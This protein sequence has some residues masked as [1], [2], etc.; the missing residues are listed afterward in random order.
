[1]AINNWNRGRTVEREFPATMSIESKT[2]ARPPITAQVAVALPVEGAFDYLIPEELRDGLPVGM[3]VLVPFGPR[4]VTGYVVGLGPHPERSATTPRLK[5]ILRPLDDEPLF[6]PEMLPFFRF[7]AE[8]YHYP[9]GL[10]IAEALPSGLKVMSRRTIRLT[11][12]GR[13]ALEL[14]E[15][16]SSEATLMTRLDRSGGLSLAGLTREKKESIKLVRTLEARSWI[17]S[18][19]GFQKDRVRPKIQKWLKPL[20]ADRAGPER[21]GPKEKAL[22]ESLN[23]NGPTPVEELRDRFPGLS[24]MIG[25][26]ERKGRL[27]VEER[28]VYRDALG[29]ALYFENKTPTLTA[30]QNL[31]VAEIGQALAGGEFCP[32]LLHGI[33][34][35]GKT[36][37][38][39]QAMTRTLAQGRTALVLVP[40]ISLTPVM[41]GLCRA[42]FQ[43]EVG[44][45][46][47][48][49][50]DGERYDQWLKI[51]RGR[52]RVVLGARSAV[53]A[54]LDRIGLI[55]VDEEHDGAYKQD[56]KLR[57]NGRDLAL[58]RGQQA[59]AVVILGSATPSVETY[60]AARSGR[61]RLLTLTRRIGQVQL[62]KVDI[63]DLRYDSGRRRGALTPVLKSA[64][65]ETLDRGEQALLFINRRGLAGTPLCLACG[66]AI[67]CL[68]CSVTMTLH[69]APNP[70]QGQNRLVCH[71]CGLETPPPTRCPNCDSKL[72][73][74]VGI[75]TERLQQEVEKAFPEAR[76]GRLDADTARPKGQMTRILEALRDRNL[77]VL[78]GTQM[79]TKGHDFPNITLVGVI[80]ADLGLH[81]PDFRA[82]ERVF[83]LLA[84]VAG[85][86]G[87]GQTPGRVIIQT[88]SPD[89][90][91]LN[92]AQKHDYPGFFKIEF[93]QR[94]ESGYP[95]FSRLVL[96]RFTGNSEEKTRAS[97][98]E[99][100]QAGR[101]LLGDQADS[102]LSI[103]GPAPAPLAR[104]KGKYRFQVLIRSA[105]VKPLH[106]FLD[107]WLSRVRPRLK[108]H[109]VTLI[110]DVDPYQMM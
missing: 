98:E 67:K 20:P 33:T 38:Y 26:L 19:D 47:S 64:L 53:F 94:R 27:E 102:P 55:I 69:Q 109:G 96:A 6:G 61:Y 71:Y 34:G 56:D 29:R 107:Q 106:Q 18:I 39:L 32:F 13:R 59:G 66:Y 99:A 91:S 7:A 68:N 4:Q 81:L 41:E 89:H 60:H 28:E 72:F 2:A 52:V 84:Q 82:G 65:Q 25:R 86:A 105:R 76:V 37:V 80:E 49:L 44:L 8:Y 17:E 104:L 23:V 31:A 35:S 74:Y 101:E 10:A 73:R 57:Y 79:V 95:P 78:A 100:A 48:G 63:V 58:V 77:D 45:L 110:L 87:R 40:E 21:L 24:A 90:Y 92:R 9:L 108:G 97:A 3:R 88:L 85:R 83:Q 93:R 42:R 75:G 30:E 70:D 15:A 54:P 50:S 12:S 16:A 14:G 62:P 22:M 5:E 36:E 11:P 51:R 1:M 43:E 46:H 103:L